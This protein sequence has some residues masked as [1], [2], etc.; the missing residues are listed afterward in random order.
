MVESFGALSIPVILPVIHR[1]IATNIIN[2]Y[3][4]GLAVQAL[5]I[6]VSR[7]KISILVGTLAMGAVVLFLFA[8]DFAELL[9]NLLATIA[10]W[11]ATWGGIMA[12]HYI[13]LRTQA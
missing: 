13:H 11:V 2:M 12:V 3:T 9:H 7:K 1:P 5:D 8:H 4:F 6:R 10:A